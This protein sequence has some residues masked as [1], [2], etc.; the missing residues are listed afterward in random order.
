MTSSRVFA[1][2]LTKRLW[3]TAALSLGTLLAS[4]V[5]AAVIHVDGSASP[6][7]N[8]QTWATAFNG[9]QDALDI[10]VS[11]DKVWV[12][13]G[14]YVPSK[15]VDPGVAR[16][17][18][19]QLIGG[20]ELYGA[21]PCGGGD[22]TFDA[23]DPYN[24]SYATVLSADI[25]T[26]GNNSDNAYHVVVG[27]GSAATAVL[28]GFT[29]TAGNANGPNAAWYNGGGLYVSGGNLTIAHCT[30]TQNVGGDDGNAVYIENGSSQ[31]TSCFF[32]DN[33]GPADGAGIYMLSS[34]AT[35]IN[36]AFLNNQVTAGITR[37]GGAMVL[38]DS[39]AATIA[40]CT[41]TRNW[42]SAGLGGGVYIAGGSQCVVKNCIFWENTGG[43][44]GGSGSKLVTFSDVQGG[45]AGEG[46]IDLN[47]LFVDP[48][49]GKLHLQAGSPCI[50]SGSIVSVPPRDVGGQPRVI[51]CVVD[52]GAYEYQSEDGL[53]RADAGDDQSHPEGSVVT[54]DGSGS[55]IPCGSAD[56]RW[57]QV[58]GEYPV[59]LNTTDPLHP[60]FTAP[61]VP[62]GGTTLTFKLIVSDGM[63]DSQPDFVNIK[64]TNVPHAPVA[65]A[66][67]DQKVAEYSLVTLNGSGSYDE[68]DDPLTYKWRQI[69]GPPPVDLP[70][71]DQVC[72]TFTAPL[73]GPEGEKLVF[74]LIVK[75]G[76]LDSPPDTVS[77]Q[78]EN[79]NHPPVADAGEH[80]TRD[81]GATVT[82][83][84]TKSY[85]PDGDELKFEWTQLSSGPTVILSDPNSPTPN[86]TAPQVGLG[87]ATLVFQVIVRDVYGLPDDDTVEI[88]V[89]YVVDPP[90]CDLGRPSV[91]E[92]WPPNH[93]LVPV[94]IVGVTDPDNDRVTITILYVTQ[95]EPVNG[96]GDGDT[97]PDAVIQGDTV[98]IRAERAGGGNGRVYVIHFEADDGVG[99]TCTGSVTVCVPHSKKDPCV[100]DGQNYSSLGP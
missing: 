44:I 89:Q 36:C 31:F 81:E 75:D 76:E 27:P 51:N 79:V 67:D 97:A 30:F 41:F 35:L 100:D 20:V 9:L 5:Q 16:T 91:A 90:R 66:G 15:P 98:L 53:P 85:D 12:A 18:T 3:T 17:A 13:V 72:I 38:N 55:S 28:D 92:L 93:K 50:D 84:A 1:L 37:A 68:D 71:L 33:I 43:S 47:P 70:P 60:T 34:S 4:S 65:D 21:F 45:C 11:G 39:S 56:Y 14:T 10:A 95:D 48:S 25:G 19:F 42:A 78:V 32:S 8:G 2:K 99:G 52:M 54:L 22:G 46:N 23:R 61:Q 58:P 29:V 73:V 26:S 69:S 86:F 64:I 87:G 6:G 63:N 40:N 82:L 77:I 74:E 62:R 80:Q 49:N 57:T 24:L 88:A 59:T 83:N 96:L 94:T 7:G